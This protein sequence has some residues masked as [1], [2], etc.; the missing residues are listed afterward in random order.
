MQCFSCI[1]GSQACRQPGARWAFPADPHTVL[2]TEGC[3]GRACGQSMRHGWDMPLAQTARQ[4]WG[5]VG[6]QAPRPAVRGLRP[7]PAHSNMVATGRPGVGAEIGL[8]RQ[9]G[10]NHRQPHAMDSRRCRGLDGVSSWGAPPPRRIPAVSISIGRD[11]AP[12]VFLTTCWPGSSAFPLS[13]LP[14]RR[15]RIIQAPP[16]RSRPSDELRGQQRWAGG[17]GHAGEKRES[18]WAPGASRALAPGAA[19]RSS[20]AAR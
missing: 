3:G 2:R 4:R 1:A 20:I 13:R 12:R 11:Q 17:A 14:A 6:M 16:A 15:K 19:Q 5:A 8:G 10:R 18:V 9:G 7:A